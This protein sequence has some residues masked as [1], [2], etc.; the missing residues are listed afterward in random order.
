MFN[1]VLRKTLNISV[2]IPITRKGKPL[3]TV[4]DPIYNYALYFA[5][6]VLLFIYVIHKKLNHNLPVMFWVASMVSFSAYGM[7]IRQVFWQMAV[8]PAL[9]FINL[10]TYHKKNFD[11][12]DAGFLATVN[13]LLASQIYETPSQV[14]NILWKGGAMQYWISNIFTARLFVCLFFLFLLQKLSSWPYMVMAVECALFTVPYW[15]LFLAFRGGGFPFH[16]IIRVP[17]MIGFVIYPFAV[18]KRISGGTP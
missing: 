5:P 10:F 2:S 4:T 7:I 6:F 16:L 14:V 13:V 17:T 18:K 1:K 8:W 12:F 9:F 11:N 15:M 3:P